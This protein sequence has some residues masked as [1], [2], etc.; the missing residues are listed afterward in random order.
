MQPVNN[1]K[2]VNKQGAVSTFRYL[3]YRTIYMPITGIGT[4]TEL[5][6]AASS[7]KWLAAHSPPT[8]FD[9]FFMTEVPDM[10]ALPR[11]DAV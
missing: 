1:M 5:F 7:R 4:R 10:E 8:G 11:G 9:V 6:Y 3:R 2:S